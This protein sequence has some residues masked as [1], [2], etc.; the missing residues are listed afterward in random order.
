MSEY[1]YRTIAGDAVVIELPDSVVLGPTTSA[2]VFEVDGVEYEFTA[3]VRS[4]GSDVAAELGLTQI[5]SFSFDRGDLSLYSGVYILEDPE[6]GLTLEEVRCIGVWMGDR[7]S[8]HVHLAAAV[9]PASLLDL[10]GHFSIKETPNGTQMAP[11]RSGA[12]RSGW[13][14]PSLLVE[15][16]GLAV[17]D[18][19]PLDRRSIRTLPTWEGTQVDGGEAYCDVDDENH[20]RLV[21]LISDSTEVTFLPDPELSSVPARDDGS[22]H[23]ATGELGLDAVVHSTR[24][25][26]ERASR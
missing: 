21:K 2:E 16:I 9:D 10:F 17:V 11:I 19:S 14:R 12:R 7:S 22:H 24:V 5:A 13:R 26:W 23:S 20:V 3:G 15:M 6:S 4:L 25:A 1:R 8:I 18:V